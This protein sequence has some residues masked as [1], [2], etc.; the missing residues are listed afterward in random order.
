MLGHLAADERA[1]GLAAALADAPDDFG[2]GPGIQ[3]AHGNV[4]EEEQ[5]L[6]TGGQNIVHAHG[7]QIDAHRIV[8]A[9]T[10]GDLQ[11][12]AHAVGAGNQ[13][14]IGHVLGGRDGE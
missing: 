12:R 4:V 2:H 1:A 9:K 14:G 3:L 10:L 8:H 5:R 11:L 6:G 13:Q 7:H